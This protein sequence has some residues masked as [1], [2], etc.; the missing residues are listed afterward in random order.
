MNDPM[1]AGLTWA[2]YDATANWEEP[3]DEVYGVPQIVNAVMVYLKESDSTMQG[4]VEAV[5]EWGVRY[6]DGKINGPTDRE[7]A[8]Y[9]T[10]RDGQTFQI[11]TRQTTH[12]P[13]TDAIG[14]DAS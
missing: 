10:T 6:Q 8:R 4:Q 5:T 1:R 3:L 2:I 9:L 11:V 13:W 12:T 14:E 7:T